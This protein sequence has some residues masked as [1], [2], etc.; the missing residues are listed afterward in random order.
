M[1]FLFYRKEFVQQSANFMQADSVLYEGNGRRKRFPG[2]GERCRKVRK[3]MIFEQF[4][5]KIQ[6][7]VKECLGEQITVE[8]KEIIKNNGVRLHGLILMKE[9]CNVAP[10][11]YL[12]SFFE[13]Y[14]RGRELGNIVLEII[15]YCNEEQ[16]V[17]SL[18]MKFLDD[19]ETAGKGIMIKLVNR[20]KNKELLEK[21]PF[22]PFLNLA[23]IFYYSVVSDFMG[24]GSILIYNEHL[25]R[26]KVD[27]QTLYLNALENTRKKQGFYIQDMKDVVRNLLR[28]QIAENMKEK[29]PQK[30]N[31]G[32]AQEDMD[33]LMKEIEKALLGAAADDMFV[34][35][36]R[37]KSQGAVCMV[38]QDYLHSFAEKLEKNLYI[39]PSSVHE[40]ILV[41]DTGRESADKL[42]EM[43]AE[44]NTTQMEPE[45]IL[46][47]DIY[48]YDRK[49]QKTILLLP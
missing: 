46:S 6:K 33:L 40:V 14:L 27:M 39:L 47:N 44:V 32:T 16:S 19:Y 13:D 15:K 5:E 42:S 28:E 26:W 25:N 29:V 8:V 45:E 43:V 35:T 10:T 49:A 22:V 21:V 2:E 12:E 37:M 38:Y 4:Q 18:D 41:P 30:G 11:I 31:G 20:E 23:V 7:S 24:N 34:L 48:Y 17:K 1:S 9:N 3:H 36:N